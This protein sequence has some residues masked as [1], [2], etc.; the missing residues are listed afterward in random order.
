MDFTIEV[1]P[2]FPRV[3]EIFAHASES[4]G[5][6]RT[7]AH[8]KITPVRVAYGRFPKGQNIHPALR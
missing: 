3:S 2:G 5:G 6:F 1:Y 8:P 7:P 4:L